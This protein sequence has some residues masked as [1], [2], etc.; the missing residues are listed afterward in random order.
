MKENS[1]GIY[2]MSGNVSEWCFDFYKADIEKSKIAAKTQFGIQD[3]G[4]L[5]VVVKGGH[6]KS[7]PWCGASF[8]RYGVSPGDRELTVGFRIVLVE[9]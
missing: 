7:A 1:W 4:A 6:F 9:S 3:L 2:G 5:K 8:F